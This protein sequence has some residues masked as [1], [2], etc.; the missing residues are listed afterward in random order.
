MCTTDGTI[1]DIDNI[2]SWLLKHGTNPVTGKKL[3]VDDLIRLKFVKNE[4]GE[5]V[6]PVTFKVFTN[7]SHIMTIK[8][9]GNVFGYDTVERLNI[10]A[11]MW[12]DLVS[13]E[14]FGRKDI[15]T[16]QDP[17]NLSGRDLSS[18][19]YIKDGVSTLTPTQE[20]ER[21]ANV[22]KSALGNAA[23]VLASTAEQPSNKPQ[24]GR[25][26]SQPT[27]K[28][29]SRT[30][31]K[32]LTANKPS[33]S[34]ISKSPPTSKPSSTTAKALHTTGQAAASL[35]STGLTPHTSTAPATL[36]REAYLLTPKR[37]KHSGY[38]TL[39]TSHG[40][41]TLEL[42]P[43]H[44]PRAVWNFISLAKKGY[45]DN[46]AFHRNIRNFMLQGGDPTGT[47][48]G[49]TSIW[50]TA[51]KDE[52]ATSPLSHDKRGVLSMANKGKDTNTSQFFITY[53]ACKHLDRKHTIFGN[54]LAGH[55][56][57]LATLKAIEAVEVEDGTSKPIEDVKIEDVNIFDDPFDR[58]LK[59]EEDEKERE[60]VREEVERNG[61]AEDER[62]TWTGKRIG[63]NDAIEVGKYLDGGGVGSKMNVEEWEQDVE[64][65][66]KKKVKASG[67]FGNFDG[68]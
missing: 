61:G 41:I 18:F 35:T 65:P 5:Y 32:A 66:A 54:I 52:W 64:E 22:N 46:V 45:Y 56:P 48:R 7:N 4:Q 21:N 58:F 39:T 40:P 15:I 34:S 43:Q 3:E 6:D 63:G 13:D 10:K 49:G 50:G 1:F 29:S 68:W 12:R 60:G 30:T 38:C 67:G 19:K 33:P 55:E 36:S 62:V 2:L 57:T 51:F 53:R 20:R 44:A 42:L 16:L 17:Q 26:L 8:N 11:K 28:S 24:V 14:E 9:T 37:V 47:G 27:S 25:Y 23:A 31:A 59:E